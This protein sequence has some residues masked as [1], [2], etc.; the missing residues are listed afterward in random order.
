MPFEPPVHGLV[1]VR[2]SFLSPTASWSILD[3]DRKQ[4]SRLVTE[5]DR[6]SG[7]YKQVR[8]YE[9][10]LSRT[11]MQRIIA[12]ANKIW[13][14]DDPIFSQMATDVIWELYL[15]DGSVI[16]REHGPGLPGGLANDLSA[17]L[18][19]LHGHG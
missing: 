6:K 17:L 14:S 10:K 1:L 11:D 5:L 19:E 12:L 18:D 16:R 8:S 7:G 4:F 2:G 3:L 15:F 9:A 13:A